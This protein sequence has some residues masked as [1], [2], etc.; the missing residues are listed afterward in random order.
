MDA[1]VTITV[2]GWFDSLPPVTKKY[3]QDMVLKA[4][5]KQG[6]EVRFSLPGIRQWQRS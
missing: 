1:H 3:V 6:W 5:K 4:E 2:G